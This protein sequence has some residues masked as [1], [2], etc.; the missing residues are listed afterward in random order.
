M[1][2]EGGY[3]ERWMEALEE[4]DQALPARAQPACP[5]CGRRELR[6]QYIGDPEDRIGYGAVWC[7]HCR[8][9]ARTGRTEI[10]AA[11]DMLPF[12]ASVPGWPPPSL[13]GH[14]RHR[15]E[16]CRGLCRIHQRADDERLAS[17]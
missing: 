4:M 6:A 15:S 3:F 2:P 17:P 7:D 10:P 16:P 11:A 12:S 1:T 14:G 5:N 13:Q 9:G 8:W